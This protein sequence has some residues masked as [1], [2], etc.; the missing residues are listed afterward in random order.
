MPLRANDLALCREDKLAKVHPMWAIKMGG[1]GCSQPPDCFYPHKNLWITREEQL[2]LPFLLFPGKQ[3]YHPWYSVGILDICFD[4]FFC[5]LSFF[6]FFTSGCCPYS[7]IS[8]NLVYGNLVNA[9]PALSIP[10]SICSWI[11]LGITLPRFK[12]IKWGESSQCSR[13]NLMKFMKIGQKEEKPQNEGFHKSSSNTLRSSSQVDS[14]KIHLLMLPFAQ[15]K[16]KE[17]WEG[18]QGQGKKQRTGS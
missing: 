7:S 8:L 15:Q 11:R 2:P 17:S 5:F 1:T 12:Q 3:L 14:R 10:L 9:T 16:R 6:F 18:A 4:F 13:N